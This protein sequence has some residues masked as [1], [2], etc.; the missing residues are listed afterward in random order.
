MGS[1]Y[2]RPFMERHDRVIQYEYPFNERIR[3]YLRLENLFRRLG[4]LVAREDALDHHFALMTMFEIMEVAGRA[5]LKSEVLKDLERQKQALNGYRGNPAISEEA[6]NHAIG[7]LDGCFSALNQ[8]TGKAGQCLTE[9][10]WLMTIRARASI[11]GGTCEFDLPGYFAW[12]HESPASRRADLE[13]WASSFAPLAESLYI[14]L[15]ML[16]DAGTAQKAIAIGGKF[17]Q[18]LP[19]ARTFHL[20]RLRVGR[21]HAAIPEIS[22]SRLLVSVRFLRHETESHLVPVTDDVPFEITLCG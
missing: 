10:E 2:D 9:N 4:L 16:R 22:G 19:Q 17:Q 14:L 1:G 21:E 11:P 7:R 8:Q 18:N 6:L 15:A 12:Q 3:T 20:M 13:R 5:D